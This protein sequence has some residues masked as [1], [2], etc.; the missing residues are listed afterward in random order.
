MSA[1][2]FVLTNGKKFIRQN[3]DGKYEQVA[4]LVMADTYESK[5]KAMNVM[6]NSISKVLSRSYYV[7]EV[8]NGELIQNCVPRPPKTIKKKSNQKYSFDTHEEKAKWY[9]GFLGVGALFDIAMQRNYELS[10]EISDIEA[11]IVD[12]EHYMDIKHTTSFIVCFWNAES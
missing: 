12:L 7:A 6:L 10:Q 11:K 5:K 8:Q 1:R 3:V 9:D 2:E 4:N